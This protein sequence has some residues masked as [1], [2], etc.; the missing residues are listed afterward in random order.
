MQQRF[1]EMK[2]LLQ[3]SVDEMDTIYYQING[4]SIISYAEFQTLMNKY[5]TPNTECPSHVIS[6]HL[7][8]NAP[9][10]IRHPTDE[11][12]F[13]RLRA[14]LKQ[15]VLRF[16]RKKEKEETGSYWQWFLTKISSTKQND[17]ELFESSQHPSA[18]ISS[19]DQWISLCL[20]PPSTYQVFQTSDERALSQWMRLSDI[21]FELQLEVVRREKKQ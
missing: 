18:D 7:I 12:L 21:K 11:H 1:D 8:F 15:R 20:P 9:Q 19:C 6:R 16:H 5:L 3:L 17:G 4:Q 14:L 13:R 10:I 2:D